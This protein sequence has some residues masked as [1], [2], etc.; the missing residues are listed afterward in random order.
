M[1]TPEQWI[2]WFTLAFLLIMPTFLGLWMWKKMS[3]ES[4]APRS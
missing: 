1:I 3:E 2:P 4:E